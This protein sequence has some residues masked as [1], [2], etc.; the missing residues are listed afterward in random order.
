M[1]IGTLK[2]NLAGYLGKGD[3]FDHA[4]GTFAVAYADQN[5]RDYSAFRAAIDTG[6]IEAYE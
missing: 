4:I 2:A 3:V 6:A 5:E 1:S